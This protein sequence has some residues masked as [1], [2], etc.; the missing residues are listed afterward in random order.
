[1]QILACT[2][3][4]R[5]DQV[6]CLRRRLLEV[7]ERPIRLAIVEETPRVVDAVPA[8]WRRRL[9]HRLRLI[10]EAAEFSSGVACCVPRVPASRQYSEAFQLLPRKDSP[11]SRNLP[12]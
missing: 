4:L 8:C 10:H 3:V 11:S 7:V 5:A 1:M 12:T 2:T 6:H 9:D